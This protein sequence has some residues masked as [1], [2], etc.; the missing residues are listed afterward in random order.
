MDT[1]A[2]MRSSLSELGDRPDAALRL[3]MRL[4]SALVRLTAQLPAVLGM[5]GSDARAMLA[6]WGG[7]RCTLTALCKRLGMS[8]A[9]RTTLA[10]RCEADGWMKR[11]P[12]LEDRRRI[13]VMATPQ[14]EARLFAALESLADDL[15]PVAGGDDWQAFARVADAVQAAA[16]EASELLLEQAP[17][18]SP[19]RRRTRPVELDDSW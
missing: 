6:L 19:A 12:D 3:V 11:H 9:A 15:A 2:L 4:N 14:F 7:G 5:S 17:A 13:L 1:V 10:D 18:V 8:R 16:V